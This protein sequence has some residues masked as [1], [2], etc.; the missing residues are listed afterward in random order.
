MGM[1]KICWRP[2][3]S[4]GSRGRWFH[5]TD[6]GGDITYHGPGQIVGYPIFDLREWKRDVGAYLRALEQAIID[7]LREF[8]IE[9][10]ANPGPPACGRPKGKSALWACIS[11]AG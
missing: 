3:L 2:T 4:F 7:T 6:R 8:G 5:E 11:A 1:R 9:A 10:A